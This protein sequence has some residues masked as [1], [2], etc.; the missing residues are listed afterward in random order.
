MPV[1][2][3]W[4]LADKRSTRKVKLYHSPWRLHDMLQDILRSIKVRFGWYVCQCGT[5]YDPTYYSKCPGCG[6]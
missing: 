6:K 3:A 4:A 5:G 2:V 1:E